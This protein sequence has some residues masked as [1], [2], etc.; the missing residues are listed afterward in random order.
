MADAPLLR[1]EGLAGRGLALGLGLAAALGALCGLLVA[2]GNP[3]AM[4]ICG[5]CNLRDIAGALGLAGEKAPAY[6]RPELLGVLLGAFAWTAGTGRVEAR[7]GSHAASRFLLGVALAFGALVFLGCPFRLFQRLGAGDGNALAGLAGFLAGVGAAVLLEAR[8]YTVGRTAIAPRPVGLLGPAVAL[9]LLGLFLA[10]GV[11]RGPGAAADGP[12]PR[13][14][15][16]LA[17]AAGLAAGAVLS[18]TG[19]CGVAAAR[20]IWLRKRAMPLA[21]LA[22]AAGYAAVAAAAGKW[23]PGF[24]GQFASH[25]DHAA[26]FLGMVLVGL[27]GAFAGGCPVRQVV[28]AGEGNGDALVTCAGIAAG[29]ALAHN[30]GLASGPAG[31]TGAGKAVAAAGIVLV[32]LYAAAVARSAGQASQRA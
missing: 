31:A 2:A 9:G 25:G 29:G 1:R 27:A 7:S 16:A 12:P 20:G 23:T 8:G 32:L 24:S 21:A 11:L 28:M 17:L 22:L 18:G 3:S 10:G 13:A 30:L 14:P 19:F 15:W 26:S 4:G 6:A 5:A